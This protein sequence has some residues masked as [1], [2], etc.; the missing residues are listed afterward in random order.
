MLDIEPLQAEEL[1]PALGYLLAI[2]GADRPAADVAVRSFLSYLRASPVRW[3]GWR[4]GPRDRPCGLVLALL[5]PGATAL[6]LVPPPGEFAIH[7]ERQ[8]ELTA[9][10]L[11]RLARRRLH[12][13]QA[14]LH[15]QAGA[16]RELLLAAGFRPLAPLVYRERAVT[17]PW[18]EPPDVPETAWTRFDAG[19]RGEFCAVL[20][21]TYE[22][23][24]DCPELAD[25]RPVD[26]VLAA[27]QA[28]GRFDPDLWEVLHL[29]GRP[30]GCVLLAPH[31]D[32]ETAELVYMGV[33]PPFR[34]RGAGALLI[35]RALQR[36][37]GR[38][39][40]RLTLAVDDRNTPAKRLYDRFSLRP[41]ARRDAYLYTWPDRG[42]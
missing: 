28:A 5:S 19:S 35:R 42:R 26:D 23:S 37:R 8:K 39:L 3:E 33:T 36:C 4:C 9:E 32:G 7:P 6:L 16:Q 38:G 25:L 27:H 18:A 40:R 22:G 15:P 2:P 17:Y 14:L 13:A 29:D 11:R 21:A 31:A 10:A 34:G 30:A 20:R 12:F 41:I 24:L 1:E